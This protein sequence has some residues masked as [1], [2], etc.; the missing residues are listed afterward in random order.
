MP[1]AKVKPSKVGA[2]T[3]YRKDIGALGRSKRPAGVPALK[4]GRMT[5]EVQRHLGYAKKP[6]KLT[7]A[8]WRKVFR[9]SELSGKSWLGMLTTQIA[10]RKFCDSASRCEAKRAFIKA[11]NVL[12]QERDLTPLLA[13]RKWKSM[14]HAARVRSRR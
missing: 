4:K 1:A 5:M 14:S 6:T 7:E 8:E 11:V 13:V 10:R 2:G 9:G 3:Y 12:A